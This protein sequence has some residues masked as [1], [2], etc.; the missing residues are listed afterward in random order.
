MANDLLTQL[1]ETTSSLE[2]TMNMF[3][4]QFPGALTKRAANYANLG[5]MWTGRIMAAQ[6]TELAYPK[7]Y[8]PSSK[9]IEERLGGGYD[10]LLWE[11]GEFPDE[12]EATKFLRSVIQ[13]VIQRY[14]YVRKMELEDREGSVYEN[15]AWDTAY[16]N[17]Q[18]A[19]MIL[20]MN[21]DAIR[22]RKK[23]LV[24]RG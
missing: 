3:H 21:L 4:A 17:L 5:N 10:N 6:A 8:D 23:T 16:V 20:G 12:I 24:G 7:S 15:I 9:E 13:V 1:K 22:N 19:K 11:A 2:S 14:E 18:N